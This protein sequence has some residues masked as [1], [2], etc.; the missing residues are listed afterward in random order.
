MMEAKSTSMAR[1]WARSS[2]VGDLVA[3]LV[4]GEHHVDLADPR[5]TVACL[6]GSPPVGTP[7]SRYK[8]EVA[9]PRRQMRADAGIRRDV[10]GPARLKPCPFPGVTL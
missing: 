1:D 5:D 7:S 8:P 6:C 4:E 3:E 10:A 9:V 2:K